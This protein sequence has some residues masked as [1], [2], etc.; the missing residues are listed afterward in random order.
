MDSARAVAW[1][2]MFL[3]V[4]FFIGIATIDS[5]IVVG[6]VYAVFV[7]LCVVLTVA[8]LWALWIMI[9]TMNGN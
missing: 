1:F 9:S 3:D 7:T 4:L 5:A 2:V 8:T 6:T